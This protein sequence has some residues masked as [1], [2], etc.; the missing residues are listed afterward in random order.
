MPKYGQFKYS[1]AKYGRYDIEIQ[2]ETVDLSQLTTYKLSSIDSKGRETRPIVNQ[3]VRIINSGGP[4]AVRIKS[5][6]GR[7][8]YHQSIDIPGNPPIIRIKAIGTNSESPWVE[9]VIGT[10]RKRVR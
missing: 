3:S 9:S 1:Q 10:I 8:V 2:D 5:D 6:N 7:W 4:I